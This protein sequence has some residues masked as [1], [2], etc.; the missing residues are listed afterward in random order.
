MLDHCLSQGG[1][2]FEMFR[3]IAVFDAADVDRVFAHF[4]HRASTE[5][6][7]NVVRSSIVFCVVHTLVAVV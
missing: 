7:M 1:F 2:K 4:C 6:V 5:S 3:G